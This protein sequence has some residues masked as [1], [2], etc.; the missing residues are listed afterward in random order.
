MTWQP[1]EAAPKDGTR[2]LTYRLGFEE[3]MAVAWFTPNYGDPCWAPVHGGCWP[4]VT[5][6]MP[7]PPPPAMAPT[8]EPK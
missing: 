7:L 1:I 5:H 6:W 4:D 2:V 3:N 8:G